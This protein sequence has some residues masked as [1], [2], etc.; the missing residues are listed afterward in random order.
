MSHR[1]RRGRTRRCARADG[2]STALRREAHPTFAPS[3]LKDGAATAGAHPGAESV[4][5][6]PLPLLWLIGAL[7][8]SREYRDLGEIFS[9]AFAGGRNP[10]ANRG[11]IVAA[12]PCSTTP[13][14]Q[15]STPSGELP[16]RGCEHRSRS[17]P[18]RSGW[19]RSNP[20]AP[21]T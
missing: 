10:P 2:A 21:T 4:G 20:S 9:T 6:C 12:P 11:G 8:R 7:H 18:T 14:R 19:S 15:T 13:F 5:L 3:A 1:D 16:S 17:R